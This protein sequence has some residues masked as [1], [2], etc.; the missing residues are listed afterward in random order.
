VLDRRGLGEEIDQLLARLD[1]DFWFFVRHAL[2][3]EFLLKIV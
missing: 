2:A 1:P 3:S